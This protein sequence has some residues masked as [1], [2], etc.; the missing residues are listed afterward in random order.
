MIKGFVQ[1]ELTWVKKD[2]MKGSHSDMGA[3]HYSYIFKGHLLAK[4]T[5]FCT[6]EPEI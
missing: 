4:T 3:G 1:R 6:I 2:S 5:T